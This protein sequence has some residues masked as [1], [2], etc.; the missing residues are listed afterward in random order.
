MCVRYTAPRCAVRTQCSIHGNSGFNL[1]GDGLL[2]KEEHAWRSRISD[3]KTVFYCTSLSS[4]SEEENKK[5][6][7]NKQSNKKNSSK[8]PIR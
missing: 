6:S 4:D 3:L 8:S 7:W 1:A 5:R 2:S